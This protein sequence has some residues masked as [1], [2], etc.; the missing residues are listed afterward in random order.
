MINILKEI[1]IILRA[2]WKKIKSLSSLKTVASSV[3]T[4]LSLDTI[5]NSCNIANTFN[6]HFAIYSW[7]YKKT[8]N[9][10][11]NIFQLMFQ[12]KVVVQYFCNL[13]LTKKN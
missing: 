3:P 13:L 7:K 6:N 10:H 5:T 8:K 9:I 4:V 1:G 2:L 11:V 12:M